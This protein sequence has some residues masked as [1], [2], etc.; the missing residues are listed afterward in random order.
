MVTFSLDGGKM[1]TFDVKATDRDGSDGGNSAIISIMVYVL[2]ETK[3]VL[4]VTDTPPVLVEQNID[5]ILGY[6]GN[7]T[8][9]EV[10]MAKLEPHHEEDTEHPDS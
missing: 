10:K 3:L 8:N 4:F 5:R 2:P 7:I 9:Y 1:Y 6:L